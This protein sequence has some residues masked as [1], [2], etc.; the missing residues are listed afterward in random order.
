[1]SLGGGSR[2]AAAPA[3]SAYPANAARSGSGMGSGSAYERRASA[4]E[5]VDEDGEDYWDLDTLV[6]NQTSVR[7][8]F[9]VPVH[10][11]AFLAGNG[12][13]RHDTLL[14]ALSLIELPFW[15]AKPLA[16][17][18]IVAVDVPSCLG[19]AV[20]DDLTASPESINLSSHCPHFFRFATSIFESMELEAKI[21][22]L[23][24][25][26]FKARLRL[27]SNY[28]QTSRLRTDLSSFIRSM[29]S[30]E[31]HLYEIG[32]ESA[33]ELEAWK[34]KG[35]ARRGRDTSHQLKRRR[36]G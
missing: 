24:A 9:N 1:M 23:V 32:L 33:Q 28:T 27:V 13:G 10:G 11:Y 35:R 29:D 31:Q 14:P 6:A 26:S 30:T 2:A 22:K 5:P 7:C 12:A 19:S 3:P 20:Q 18:Q 8:Q 17:S 15:L 34:H 25:D 21:P 36:L 16:A 4:L